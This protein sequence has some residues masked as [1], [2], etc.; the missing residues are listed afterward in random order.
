MS[1]I[2][3]LCRQGSFGTGEV[4]QSHQTLHYIHYM[5][6]TQAPSSTTDGR[7][8]ITASECMEK[9]DLS[10]LRLV[11]WDV[12]V[13]YWYPPQ[14]FSVVKCNP[15]LLE[16]RLHWLLWRKNLCCW[17]WS[18][19]LCCHVLL[20]AWHGQTYVCQSPCG[21]KEPTL[22]CWSAGCWLYLI[23]WW[24]S[25]GWV[26]ISG[27]CVCQEDD[28]LCFVVIVS[29]SINQ[30]N[31]SMPYIFWICVFRNSGHCRILHQ[32]FWLMQMDLCLDLELSMT[33]FIRIFLAEV[34]SN[35]KKIYLARTKLQLR[36]SHPGRHTH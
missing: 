5:F 27:Q 32:H 15:E 6:D 30:Y 4:W 21:Y 35:K 16:T 22:P 7:Y 13:M 19:C 11:D 33:N 25:L 3:T 9:V 36:T 18:S 31:R 29:Q 23:L 20:R 34:W 2:I 1:Y 10:R 28:Q 24:Q 26:R 17:P 14:V 12:E 8:H